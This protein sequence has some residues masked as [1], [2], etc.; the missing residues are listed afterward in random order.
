[1]EAF[2]IVV[3]AL[4]LVAVIVLY[5]RERWEED[6]NWYLDRAYVRLSYAREG[7][8]RDWAWKARASARKSARLFLRLN[9]RELARQAMRAAIKATRMAEYGQFE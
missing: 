1:M 4:A 5:V 7:L 9:K 3:L 8:D 6:A 2:I